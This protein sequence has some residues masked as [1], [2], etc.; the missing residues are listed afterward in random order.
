MCVS[1]LSAAGRTNINITSVNRVRPASRPVYGFFTSRVILSSA[2]LFKFIF[3]LRQA[4]MMSRCWCNN[5]DDI[6]WFGFIH[7]ISHPIFFKDNKRIINV[8]AV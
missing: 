6:D 1:S 7:C 8:I 4:Y 3:C 5:V 2:S